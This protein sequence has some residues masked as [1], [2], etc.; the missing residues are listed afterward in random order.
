MGRRGER[1]G[2]KVA[3]RSS[4]AAVAVAAALASP[5]EAAAAAGAS[6][7]SFAASRDG[8]SIYG[9]GQS[10]SGKQREVFGVEAEE[11]REPGEVRFGLFFIYQKLFSPSICVFLI[12]P[13]QVEFFHYRQE[14]ERTLATIRGGK[15][16]W[17][18][19]RKENGSLPLHSRAEVF[20]PLSVFVFFRFSVFFVS[21]LKS[22]SLSRTR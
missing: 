17:I 5:A 20:K 14:C 1:R 9:R 12:F 19:E 7:L 6:F 11:E 4:P 10:G 13:F 16:G 2:R 15:G 21:S 22:L 3:A 18:W 8:S